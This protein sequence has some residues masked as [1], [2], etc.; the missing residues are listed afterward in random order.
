MLDTIVRLMDKTRDTVAHL[1]AERQIYLR[2]H[3]RV[4]FISLSPIAQFGMA[5]I[6]VGFLSWVAFTSVNVVFKEQIIA[7]K[8]RRFVK[9]Q[10]A[11]EERVAQMQASYDDLNGQLIIAQERFLATTQELEAKHDQISEILSHRQAALEGVEQ[12]R[13]QLAETQAHRNTSG[14][15]NKVLM[16]LTEAPGAPRVSRTA[17]ATVT[18]AAVDT[19]GLFEAFSV[20]TPV[21]LGSLLYG[22]VLSGDAGFNLDSRLSELDR[23]QQS[24]INTMEET[25]DREIRELER[26]I[27]M[28]GVTSPDEFMERVGADQ[29]ASG[30]P[31]IDLTGGDGL[32]GAGTGSSFNRQI[33]RVSQNLDRLAAL[34]FTVGVLP[35]A[36]PLENF[37]VTSDFG[38]RMDPFKRRMAF[39]SGL[40]MAAGYNTPV[41]APASGVVIYAERRGPYGRMVEVDHG[42]GFRTRYAHLN[43][44]NVSV[45][46]EVSFQDL[47]GK[48]GSSG[49]SS[50]PHLHYE[51]WFD[52]QLRD[53]SKFIEAGQYVFTH[54][55]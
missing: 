52:D 51:V 50:G 17:A 31:Y 25:T 32:A 41:Y 6:A 13:T 4:Q 19:G 22:P 40:D 18:S 30:G 5:A 55:G 9:V 46:Q 36:S 21:A 20:D 15:G 33:Q 43:R 28:I 44:I 26:V 37:R 34:N 12:L 45:G 14:R 39:H 2:S 8:D 38:P 48:V 49:R 1:Y 54:Q 3:G 47:I 27:D 35:L 23:A 42:N 24:L 16:A 53:P 10:S 11:Y 29:A 7:S